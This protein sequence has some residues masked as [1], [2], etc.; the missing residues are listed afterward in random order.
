MERLRVDLQH[1]AR[2]IE[3]GSKVLDIGC[4]D[5]ALLA[6]LT[7]SNAV[8]GYGLE[9][10]DANVAACIAKGVNVIQRDVD[11]GLSDFED[12]FFDYVI[13]AQTIQ[14][15]RYP[16]KILAEMLRIG[17]QGIVTLPN[18]GHWRIRLQMLLRGRTPL[19]RQFPHA[20][21]DTPNI[22]VCTI[23][24]FE[25]FCRSRKMKILDSRMFGENYRN[26]PLLD[27]F[28]NLLSTVAFYKLCRNC[29]EARVA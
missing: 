4:G 23:K 18:L 25:S 11:T 19:T 6:Y 12:N 22:H 5:G 24:D 28:P 17:R 14:A 15:V 3:P 8:Q 2:W 13:M 29:P 1:I 10:D 27:R 9:I 26:G 16:E 21:Y 7:R 20:W